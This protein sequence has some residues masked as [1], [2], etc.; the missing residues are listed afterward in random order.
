MIQ[1]KVRSNVA[2]SLCCILRACAESNYSV[3]NRTFATLCFTFCPTKR[4]NNGSTSQCVFRKR[5]KRSPFT[6]FAPLTL[7]LSQ[8]KRNVRRVVCVMIPGITPPTLGVPQPAYSANLP[9]ALSPPVDS[10]SQLP[11][12]QSLFS[13]ACPTRAPGEKNRMHSGYQAFTN[14]PLTGGEKERREKAR[15]E[16]EFVGGDD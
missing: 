12:F 2:S 3:I 13:H 16:R 15:K 9:F 7:S 14:C 11:V 1:I 10:T 6:F 8:N 5:N 4:L